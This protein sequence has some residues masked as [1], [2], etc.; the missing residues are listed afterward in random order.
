MSASAALPR[1]RTRLAV[2][3]LTLFAALFFWRVL[4]RED[5]KNYGFASADLFLYYY[6]VYDEI[7]ARVR[8]GVL[9]RWNPWQLSGTP[10]LAALQAGL[11]YPG[12]LLYLV[13]PTRIAMAGAGIAH[14][15]LAA[16]GT[17]AF[18]RRAGLGHLGALAAGLAF[19]FRGSLVGCLN[20]PNLEEAAAW[21]GIGALGAV[22]V[23]EQRD[24][25][26][27]ATLAT[28]AA[29]SLLAGYPQHTLY[30]LYAWGTLWLV[31]T[32]TTRPSPA[33]LV[34][35]GTAFV[36]AIALGALAA[37]AQLLPT[38]EV[39]LAASRS[40]T[41]LPDAAVSPFG[42]IAA[43]L[44]S[45]TPIVGHPLSFGVVPLVLAGLAT[46]G[47]RHRALA[48]WSLGLALVTAVF[49]LGPTT[50]WFWL[51][52]ALPGM[53][54]FRGP[55][56]LLLLV[57][58]GVAVAG[59]VA[60]D[61]LVRGRPSPSR[62]ALPL[63][64]AALPLGLAALA[65]RQGTAG[66]AAVLAGLAIGAT[67]VLTVP[68]GRA[69][70]VIGGLVV[71]ALATELIV[72]ADPQLVFPYR[73]ERLA[74]LQSYDG[75]YDQLAAEA[76]HERTWVL[77]RLD[78]PFATKHATRRRFR[79][80]E[81][82]EPVN[83]RRQ[84]QYL[85]FFGE[86]I[87]TDF[88]NGLP[89][90]GSVP[91]GIGPGASGT[92]P[93]ARRRLLDLAGVT[94]IL[95]S[96]D[97]ARRPQAEQ[98]LTA[99]GLTESPGAVPF[100]V[101]RNPYALP[102][103]YVVHRTSPAPPVAEL[104]PRLA[105]P[106]LRP[107]RVRLGRG[108]P[109]VRSGGR[110]A[111]ARY[112]GPLRHGRRG[113][114]RGR[115]DGAGRGPAR[116][117][118]HLR[119]RLACD[120]RRQRGTDRADESSLPRRPGTCRHA[121]R[122]LHLPTLDDPRRAAAVAGRRRAARGSLMAV[123]I[124]SRRR[125]RAEA[126]TPVTGND[127]RADRNVASVPWIRGLAQLA[128]RGH[129]ATPYASLGHDGA[130]ELHPPTR[131]PA[132]WLHRQL[133][134]VALLEERWAQLQAGDR[135]TRRP[136]Q[137]EKLLIELDRWYE[138]TT[139]R[140]LGRSSSQFQRNGIQPF[141]TSLQTHGIATAECLDPGA[142]CQSHAGTG[143]RPPERDDQHALGTLHRASA[144]ADGTR[145]RGSAVSRRSA[146]AAFILASLG[147][148][149]YG[150]PVVRRSPF[151]PLDLDR[152]ERHRRSAETRCGS[153]L[154]DTGLQRLGSG[155]AAAHPARSSPGRPSSGHPRPLDRRRLD[156]TVPARRAP[157]RLRHHPTPG[158]AGL[159]TQPRTPT[160]HRG[161]AGVHR[162]PARMHRRRRPWMETGR[163]PPRTSPSSSP[164]ST[165]TSSAASS[166]RRARAAPRD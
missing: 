157:A 34:A 124:R 150:L 41:A 108:R 159:A 60:V 22:L 154:P 55:D 48:G 165:I 21:I 39:V 111:R 8:A 134:T 93:G 135:T 110:R 99:A 130:L 145:S 69:A 66:A 127:D 107:A 6:P 91:R 137:P 131:Y 18:T 113:R 139:A 155:R 79:S 58:F 146:P 29:M 77:R 33:T 166:S 76:A 88:V 163:T 120:R 5:P 24:A 136:P 15:L 152:H 102:R 116:P 30:L 31:W 80:I 28:A 158:R 85:T 43:N 96:P 121:P 86:G 143:L 103:A 84:N 16:V 17:Y 122:A 63:A 81:D 57:D 54:L 72:R 90:T 87:V 95:M 73:E 126:P 45:A 14:L 106:S 1:A 56:R 65:F 133:V 11:Y 40:T 114:R 119:E 9:P 164:A 50:R 92:S 32:A 78:P 144:G 10:W 25:T 67:V 125:T 129:V 123:T 98:F 156:T 35:G 112:A 44:L 141:R 140:L 4:A 74:W 147:S 109:R 59:G 27:L 115:D 162:R 105:D 12:H 160:R 47:G 36:A 75:I 100:V 13:L 94:R 118:R 89:F 62:R 71:A 161:R 46:F 151:R 149:R 101:V 42:S 26:A 51:L 70:L 38:A 64:L 138:R 19:G 97:V 52:R 153:R 53:A 7:Y 104:L 37:A 3:G 20:G 83:L 2:A 49:S 117:R 61:A 68:T 132:W 23:A 148:V 128:S 82:Y 142:V